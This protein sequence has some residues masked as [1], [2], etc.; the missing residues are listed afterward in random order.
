[1]TALL[2]RSP[3]PAFAQGA[4]QFLGTND[5]T[6]TSITTTMTL[7]L[8]WLNNRAAVEA[9]AP[10]HGFDVEQLIAQRATVFLLGAEEAQVAPLMCAL[11]GHIARQARRIATGRPGG[12]LDPPLGLYLDEAFLICPVPLESWTADMGGRNVTIIAVFQSRQQMIDRYGPAKTGQIMTNA[13]AKVV[14]GGTGDRD[15]LMFWSTLGGDRDEPI[16]TTDPHGRGRSRTV[17]SVPVMAPAQIANL[18]EGRVLVFRR[19][20]STPS[21]GVPGW[22]GIAGTSALT[23]SPWRTRS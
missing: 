2:Q 7:A 6:Q 9:A 8:G 3:M 16:W 11:T 1:V 22:R 21:S 12:R 18:P 4:T 13:A 20:G 5:K 14:F 23:R 17:R 15:D 19:G 10:G